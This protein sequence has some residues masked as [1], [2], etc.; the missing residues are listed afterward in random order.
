MKQLSSVDCTH[1]HK[2]SSSHPNPGEISISFRLLFIGFRC[3]EQHTTH[4][5][6]SHGSTMVFTTSRGSVLRN[7]SMFPSRSLQTKIIYKLCESLAMKRFGTS[8][9]HQLSAFEMQKFPTSSN[10]AI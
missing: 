3:R 1:S 10:F 7:G 2:E 5:H 9:S 8:I 4:H 6:R